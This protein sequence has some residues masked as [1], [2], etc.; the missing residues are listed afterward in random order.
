MTA[1]SF[2]LD[3]ELPDYLGLTD[4]ADS[5]LENSSLFEL[6]LADQ[7]RLSSVGITVVGKKG[8]F[9][10]APRGF[11]LLIVRDYFLRY[12]SEDFGRNLGCC[13]SFIR[14]HSPR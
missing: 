2:Y 4:L 13:C 7:G 12:S 14:L 5:V 11:C 9:N 1:E 10:F 3:L 8:N 6:A